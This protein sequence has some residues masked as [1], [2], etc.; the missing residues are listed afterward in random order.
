MWMSLALRSMA[1]KM[2][3]LTRVTTGASSAIS[4]SFCSFRFSM[5]SLSP[6]KTIRSPLSPSLGACRADRHHRRPSPAVPSRKAMIDFSV[7]RA[8]I[9]ARVRS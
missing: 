9:D 7:A 5:P 6:E 2:S 1:P 3:P 4:A 8:H